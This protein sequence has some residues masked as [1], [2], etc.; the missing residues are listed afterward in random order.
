MT[1]LEP[2]VEPLLR[3]VL[4]DEW[5]AQSDRSTPLEP[6][7]PVLAALDLVLAGRPMGIFSA[8]HLAGG[9]PDEI[10]AELRGE[11]PAELSPWT[12]RSLERVA[13]LR[14]PA[15]LLPPGW[16]LPALP[17]ADEPL[18][19]SPADVPELPPPAP[20]PATEPVRR[21][22]RAAT[23]R[24]VLVSAPLAAAAL[25]LAIRGGAL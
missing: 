1:L 19:I 10:V 8:G 23:A 25:A 18:A 3:R 9:T 5:D 22:S 24:V 2:S 21:G 17:P 20:E 4:N 7:A 14:V 12:R 6:T 11:L 15:P 13:A 16:E